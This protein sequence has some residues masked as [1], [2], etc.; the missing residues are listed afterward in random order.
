MTTPA[1]PKRQSLTQIMELKTELKPTPKALKKSQRS[2]PA[3]ES[4]RVRLIEK[5]GSLFKTILLVTK[6]TKNVT[7][8]RE[9]PRIKLLIKGKRTKVERLTP[10]IQISATARSALFNDGRKNIEE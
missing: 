7:A 6:S 8:K 5:I 3:R 10:T 1:K 9:M 4:T 2:Q